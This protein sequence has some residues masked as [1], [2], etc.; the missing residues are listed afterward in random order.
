QQSLRRNAADVET[1]AA[2]GRPAFDQRDLEPEV[3]GAEGSGITA[4]PRTEHGEPLPDRR[5]SAR[6]ASFCF[7]TLC[8]AVAA[9]P[10]V[11]PALPGVVAGLRGRGRALAGYAV[12]CGLVF[13]RP[14]CRRRI[15][16]PARANFRL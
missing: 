9:L 12:R 11:F 13:V 10:G 2:K 1:D 7:G 4:R 14:G 15:R 5:R 3:R 8:R 6:A 16:P